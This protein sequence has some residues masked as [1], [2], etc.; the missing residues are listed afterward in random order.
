MPGKAKRDPLVYVGNLIGLSLVVLMA[1]ALL[2]RALGGVLVGALFSGA[3]LQA[4]QGVPE[5]V[6][7]LYNVLLPLAS[8]LPAYLLLRK[9]GRRVQLRIPVGMGVLPVK[10]V[11]PLYLG[12]MVLLNTLSSAVYNAFSKPL[13]LPPGQ[14]AGVPET[15]LGLFLYF[16]A[17]C[18]L[19]AFL[20]EQVFRGAMQSLLRPWGSRF[21]IL[22]TSVFFTA[23]H[24]DLERLVAVFALSVLLGFV[25]EAGHSVVPCILLHLASNSVSF[26]MMVFQRDMR[27]ETSLAFTFWMVMLFMGLFGGALWAA[28]QHRFVQKYR[29]PKDPRPEKGRAPK[30]RRLL[31]A[32]VLIGSCVLLVGYTVLRFTVLN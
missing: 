30:R 10:I 26:F 2:V 6:L 3:T 15:G 9:G 31:H 5:W 19:P 7:G 21:A 11:L 8:L 22:F 16:V 27:G 24:A 1:G 29:L 32:Y 25:A 17:M 13:R 12:L 23:L 14:A 28:R 4:P 18:V 20:E